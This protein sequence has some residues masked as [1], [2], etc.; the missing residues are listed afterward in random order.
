LKELKNIVS[1]ITNIDPK[2]LVLA[3]TPL[4][5]ENEISHFF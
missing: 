4:E 5:I 1:F 2:D 3:P